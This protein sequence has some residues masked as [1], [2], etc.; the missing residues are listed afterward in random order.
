[1]EEGGKT[2][3][4]A[5]NYPDLPGSP[6]PSTHSKSKK[7]S[8]K[9]PPSPLSRA[10]EVQIEDFDKYE[11]RRAANGTGI[12]SSLFTLSMVRQKRMIACYVRF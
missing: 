1:M 3:L 7:S 10:S 11:V 12:F 8:T 6:D 5:L 9:A 2:N 4:M